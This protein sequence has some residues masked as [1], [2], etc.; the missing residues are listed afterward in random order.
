[1]RIVFV[2][3]ACAS[4][5]L[6]PMLVGAAPKKERL[7]WSELDAR[8]KG[9]TVAFVLPDG[10]HVKGKVLGAEADGLRIKVSQTSN[11]KTQGKGEHLILAQSLSVLRVKKSGKKWRI[12]CTAAA[13]FVVVSAIAA[14]AGDLPEPGASGEAAVRVGVYASL[15]GGYILGWSLDKKETEI[16]I[17][18]QR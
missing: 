17:I 2:A 9:R 4:L 1:M 8:I 18:R 5:L 16:Q 15:A 3:S 11:P 10:T 12:L 6:G 7:E 14:A 13:P